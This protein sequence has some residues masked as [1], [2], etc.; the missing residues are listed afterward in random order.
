MPGG[1]FG[2]FAYEYVPTWCSN[3]TPQG[4]R[5]KFCGMSGSEDKGGDDNRIQ[6]LILGGWVTKVLKN[7][8]KK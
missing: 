2:H 8:D 5:S 1:Y 7:G 3:P 6:S 4:A